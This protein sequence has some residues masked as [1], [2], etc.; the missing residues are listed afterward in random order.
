VTR[1]TSKRD[2]CVELLTE[3]ITATNEVLDS[4]D[5]LPSPKPPSAQQLAASLIDHALKRR[6]SARQPHFNPK[7]QHRE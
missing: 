1:F 5:R 2:L 6:E 4:K 7:D 3:Y